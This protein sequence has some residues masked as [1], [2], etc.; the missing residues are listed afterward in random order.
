MPETIGNLVFVKAGGSFLT[1]KD[2]P[3]SM[4]YRALE[5]LSE[6][7]GKGF[8]SGVRILLG[9]GG[10]SFAHPVVKALEGG[11]P[12]RL[13]IH[14]QRATRLLNRIVVDQLIDKGIPA[15]SLQTS[16]FIVEDRD[17]LRVFID[18]LRILLDGNVIPVVYGE[19]IVS[20]RSGYR[21]LS[22]EDVF[23]VVAQYVKPSR[24][25]LLTDVEG[26]YTCDP[27]LCRDAK[28]IRRIDRGNYEEVIS[29]VSGSGGIDVTG[30]IRGKIDKMMNISRKLGIPVI[31]VSGFN[32][33]EASRAIIEG[34]VEEGTYISWHIS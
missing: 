16:A 20:V 17:G 34:V 12:S 19:C 7:I 15:T 28:L 11:D 30:G 10:G 22:T 8:R 26:V 14:C 24:I 31:I 1:F 2:K 3:F 27:K 21:V 18:P 29:M 4:N 23:S 6:I 13:L 32:T 25:V 33:I 9:N 5:K